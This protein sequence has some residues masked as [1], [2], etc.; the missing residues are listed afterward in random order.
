[1]TSTVNPPIQNISWDRS[2]SVPTLQT[3]ILS[4]NETETVDYVIFSVLF[5]NTSVEWVQGPVNNGDY[6]SHNG[7]SA[8]VPLVMQNYNDLLPGSYKAKIL[9][10]LSNVDGFIRTVEAEV[11]LTL[12]TNPPDAIKTDKDNYNVLYQRDTNTFSGETTVNILNNTNSDTLSLDTIGT[13]L[14]EKTFTDTFTLEEDSLFP[15]ATNSELPLSGQQVVNCR[16]KFGTSF[17]YYFTVTITVIESDEIVATP[18]SMNFDL[19]KDFAETKSAVLSLVNP[20]NHAFTISGPSWL[21]FSATSGSASAEITVTTDNSSTLALGSLTDEIVISYDSKTLEIPVSLNVTEFISIN[22]TD[23]NFCLDK[24]MLSATRMVE[25][26]VFLRLKFTMEFFTKKGA[27]TKTAEYTIP[28]FKGALST[29]IGEK[30][31]NFFVIFRE[32][33]FQQ[34]ALQFNNQLVYRPAKVDIVVDE[35]DSNYQ[36]V[37]SK[38]L[39]TIEFFAG[40][41]PKLFPLFTNHSFRRKIAGFQHI[42]SYFTGLESGSDFGTSPGNAQSANDVQTVFFDDDSLIDYDAIKTKYD[43]EFI[44]FPN[45]EKVITAQWLNNN[46]VPESFVFTGKYQLPIDFEDVAD[47]FEENAE[48]FSTREKQKFTINT[49][50][51][52]AEEKELIR[53]L[54]K[55]KL[56]FINLNGTVLKTNCTTAKIVMEDS[57]NFQYQYELEFKI[58]Q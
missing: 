54:R 56:V 14:K 10:E 25:T 51:L 43:L 4:I 19:R 2:G 49:G 15:F 8:S 57:E 18:E 34:S 36:S 6:I 33:L 26:A 5:E 13:L 11:N 55:S 50:W 32:H 40:K 47:D 1:M 53:E 29:D 48:R 45:T 37:Y 52:L 22:L 7:S 20:L 46:L 3:L 9:L 39:D 12:T 28:Y 44:D 58:I 35:L 23:Y 21:N 38:T 42:F 16:L 31:Q 30:V 17:I 27:E 41:K 24:I